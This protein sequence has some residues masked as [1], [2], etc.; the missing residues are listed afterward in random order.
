MLSKRAI[1]ASLA[2]SKPRSVI[3]NWLTLI[4]V[5]NSHGA[6]GLFGDRPVLLIL[7][8]LVVVVVLALLLR[9]TLRR[10]TLAQAGFGLI[11]GG[12]IG[13]VIDRLVHHFVVDFISV[14][15][16]YIFNGADACIAVG[17]VLLILSALR[18]TARA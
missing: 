6:M 3:P 13:N 17:V 15:N 11:L 2:G 5:P 7:L 9:E 18:Q 8:A 10:S 14:R 16:F 1:V 12:A 4:Y